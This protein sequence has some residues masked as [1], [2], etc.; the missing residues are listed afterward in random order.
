[1][2]VRYW[3]SDLQSTGTSRARGPHAPHVCVHAPR[4][5]N[6]KGMGSNILVIWAGQT[7]IPFKGMGKGR[8]LHLYLE[9][10][11]Y[12]RESIPEFIE[13]GGEYDRWGVRIPSL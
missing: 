13:V 4:L 3:S 2:C 12:V 8:N 5:V 7:S 9:D 1:M 10:I 11:D 6:K